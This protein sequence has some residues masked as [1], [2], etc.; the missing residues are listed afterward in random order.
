MSERRHMSSAGAAQIDEAKVEAFVEKAVG[1]FSGTM[2]V[3]LATLGDRLGLFKDL[4]ENGP[5]TAAELA[6]RTNINERYALEW[7]RGM[8][9]ASYLEY[10]R[11][12]DRFT[13]P[14]EHA[15]VL[16]QESGPMFLMGGY[17]MIP[18]SMVVLD[19][20]TER[21][22]E[23]GGV[24]QDAYPDDFWDGMQRF[25]SGYFEN[26]LVPVWIEAMPDAKEKLES[27]ALCADVG[28][29][30]GRASIKLATEF[31]TSRHV[32]YDIS[33]AQLERATTNAK[34]AGLGD[35]IRFEKR[36]VA[37]E[38]LPEKYDIITTFDVI[39]DAVDPGG[40]LK[41]IH[42]GLEDDS[43]YVC[44]DINCQDNPDDNEGPLA[45]MFYGFSVLY[46]MTTSLANNGDGLGT[47]GLPEAKLREL[48]EKAGFSKVRRVPL[49]D[50]FNNLYEVKA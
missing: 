47:C 6:K 8:T 21:F 18:G 35:H 19:Q 33:N 49:E 30:S 46:C 15:P 29:G 13:L 17:Q 24:K 37:S 31:P 42:H 20:L 45:A 2:T 12:S 39:H 16:A 7:L 34:A 3:T 22:R 43:I 44:L 36:D 26:L 5:A 14:P 23:G 4:A 50:P 27:G 41:A 28:C 25:S 11:A 9:S 32:G 38:G 1:D 40:L 48:C 10:D